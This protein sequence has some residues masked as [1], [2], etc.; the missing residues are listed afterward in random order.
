MEICP[1]TRFTM[2]EG[3]K[4]GFTRRWPLLTAV[5]WVSSRVAR[6]P[7]P[8]PTI[9]PTRS[10]SGL[11]IARAASLRAICVAARPNWMKRSLRRASFLSMNCAGSKSLTSPAMRLGRSFASKRVMGPM[12][13]FPARMPCQVG[14]LPIPSG[15]T[16][17]IPVTTTLRS[18]RC[19]RPP[20]M[21]RRFLFLVLVD[22]VDRVLDRL[23]VLR[24][25]VRDLDLEL[26]SH[27][28]HQ[29]DDVEGV[30][31][32]VFD[33]GGLRLD[34]VFPDPEL[35][36]DDA[37]DLRLDRHAQ[38]LSGKMGRRS[39]SA[40][41]CSTEKVKGKTDRVTYAAAYRPP[42][43]AGKAYWQR[44][45]M[46]RKLPGQSRSDWQ[47]PPSARITHWP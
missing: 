11:S 34:L 36:R 24:L 7:M 3:M 30:G 17:P 44:P 29:L 39:S 2:M 47:R 5:R 8:L 26:L 19:I 15:V 35:L 23:D 41:P 33:E 32:Q 13:L 27:R 21:E 9:T 6:P 18:T 38:F 46:H 4:K 37:L 22:E 25:F 1:P 43:V 10:P 20:R 14:S 45:L 31:A 40:R 42:P 16:R 12:P 28:H